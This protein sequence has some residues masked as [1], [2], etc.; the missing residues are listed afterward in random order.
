MDGDTERRHR[1]TAWTVFGVG[2]AILAGDALLAL[3]HDLLLEGPAPQGAWASR[4][5]SAAVQRLIAGQGA[6]LAFERRDDVTLDECLRDGRGQDRRPDGLRL[7]HRRH[8]RRRARR[9]GH[10]PGR[11]RRARRAGLP[12]H[13]RPARHLGRAGGDRQAGQVRPAGQEEVAA[14]GRRADQRA[15]SRGPELAELLA[16]PGRRSAR[17]SCSARPGWSRRPAAGSGRRPRPTRRWPRRASAWPRPRCPTTCA[18][19]SPAIAEFVTRARQ[20]REPRRAVVSATADVPDTGADGVTAT[21][22]RV[23]G[24]A[25][26]ARQRGRGG[27]GGA[28]P[29]RS[30]LLGLQHDEGWW[31]GELET[32][33]TMDA[34]D[35]LLREFLGIRTARADRGRRPLD[36]V[37]PARGRHL[38][39]LPRRRRPTCPPRSRPTWRCGWPATRR[40]PR[41]WPGGAAWISDGGRHRGDPGVHPDLAGAVRRSGPGTTCRSCRRS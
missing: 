38:G 36:Q 32:N 20:M 16:R 5:L 33:V 28:G 2:P 14:G 3:A 23:T 27:A 7:Q 37:L 13:R 11:V 25:A 41:T 26:R 8:L 35:L 30:H 6:D 10:G 29:R 17:T 12:A 22:D 39:E 9:P 19:S 15:P 40:T 34:E 31:Q 1:P 24:A 21:Q 4:C 18:P